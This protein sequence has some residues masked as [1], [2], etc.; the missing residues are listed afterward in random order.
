MIESPGQQDLIVVTGASTGIGAATARELAKRGFHVLAGVR[1]D[2]DANAIK[3]SNIEPLIIDITN[4]DQIQRFAHRV[5]EDPQGRKLRALINNA[6]VQAN[7][8]VEMFSLEEW[9]RMFEVNLFGQVAIIQALL[10]A[11]F[12]AKVEYLTLAQ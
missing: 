4:P 7:V 3:S 5:H 11:L 9:R 12:V 2:Q 6:A 8:P 10:P 1:R